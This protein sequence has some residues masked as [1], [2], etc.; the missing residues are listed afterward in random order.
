MAKHNGKEKAL[1]ALLTT[2]TVKEAAEH[3]GTSVATLYRYLRDVEFKKEYREARRDLM[4]ATL[5]RLQNA[6]DQ[7]VHTLR[8]NM[9]CGTPGSEVRA[10]QI[11]IDNAL[12]GIEQTEILERLEILEAHANSTETSKT[13]R[14]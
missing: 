13:G 7:A 9:S 3:C 14:R 10:A 11:V 4:E 2:N 8:R 5:G 1:T 12:R 6:T